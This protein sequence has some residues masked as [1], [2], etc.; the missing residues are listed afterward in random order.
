MRKRIHLHEVRVGMYVEEL[1]SSGPSTSQLSGPIMSSADID[2]VINS[3]AISVVI[4][5]HK[6]LD[7]EVASAK[8]NIF[9]P[10]KFD[11][12]LKMR[13]SSEHLTDLSP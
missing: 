6:G 4:D 3:H 7:V 8:G 13:F 11:A 10:I 5:T 12:A 2:R 9:D 1:E